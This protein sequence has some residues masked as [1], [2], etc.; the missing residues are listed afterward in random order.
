MDAVKMQTGN[1]SEKILNKHY[2][3]SISEDH[4]DEEFYINTKSLQKK[5]EAEIAEYVSLP[6]IQ[7]KVINL[8]QKKSKSTIKTHRQDRYRQKILEEH[9]ISPSQYHKRK[10]EGYYDKKA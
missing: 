4:I 5:R 8:I 6:S 3:K 10:R 1:K 2:D 9:G 7:G